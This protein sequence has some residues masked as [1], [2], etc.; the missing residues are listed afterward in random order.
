L[1]NINRLAV[2]ADGVLRKRTAPYLGKKPGT[3]SPLRTALRAGC[4]VTLVHDVIVERCVLKTTPRFAGDDT[5]ALMQIKAVD[6]LIEYDG[7]GV[8]AV[9]DVEQYVLAEKSRESK[10]GRGVSIVDSIESQ[11]NEGQGTRL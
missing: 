8:P 9:E 1:Y 7:K 6:K 10:E 4:G 2:H 5:D 3:L 11:I